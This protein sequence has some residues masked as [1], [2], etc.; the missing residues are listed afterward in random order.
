MNKKM[1]LVAVLSV[2]LF[3]ACQ[4]N[5]E[6][7]QNVEVLDK[8]TVVSTIADVPFIVA[9]RYFVNNTVKEV[10]NPKIATKEEFDKL[11]GMAPVM[12]D[13]GLPTTIDFAKQ[14]VIAVIKSETDMDTR[15]TPIS[16]QANEKNELV[17][18]YQIS[19]GEKLTYQM[20]P[21]LIIVVNRDVAGNVV[22]KEVE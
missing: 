14:Y 7:K 16:L 6:K 19:V 15:L 22:L 8:A 21:C 12:G 2:S 5:Q 20:R 4:V 9:D 11:F 18:S 1:V 13:N 3:A 10:D 17:F